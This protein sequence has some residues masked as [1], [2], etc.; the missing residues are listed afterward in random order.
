[1]AGCPSSHQDIEKRRWNLGTSS[2]VVEFPPPYH[3]LLCFVLL[4]SPADSRE[5]HDKTLFQIYAQPCSGQN[6]G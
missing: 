5:W 6:V 3:I 2:A 1:M 4:Y